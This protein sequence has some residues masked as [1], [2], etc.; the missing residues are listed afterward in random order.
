MVKG[1]LK[2]AGLVL[3]LAVVTIGAALFYLDRLAAVAIERGG[4][5]ALG[6]KTRV[7]GVSLKPF[8][9]HIGL[10]G[11]TVD[12]PAGF[13]RPNFLIVDEASL[14]VAMGTLR[15]D[16][17]RAR[18]FAVRGIKLD[19]EKN[20]RGSNYD[21]IL[22]NLERFESGTAEPV[23]ESEDP[24]TRFVIEEVD[25]RDIEAE[26]T[27]VVLGGE[28]QRLRVEVP[29][30]TLR[31]VGSDGAVDMAELTNV[32][33]KSVLE[34]VLSSDA[35]P[36]QLAADLR[37]SLDDLAALPGLLDAQTNGELRKAADK[38]NESVGKAF[39]GLFGGGKD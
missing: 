19:L 29:A 17:V 20:S 21:A 31:D 36:R 15:E 18:R 9:G 6:V 3:L 26:V 32:I 10:T 4:S 27:M 8:A 35:L 11:F 22:N 5:H 28:P 23:P 33:V 14:D 16:V 1:I 25:I 2:M 7:D 13:D 12:N 24:G 39:D 30:V 37:D 34:A 38:I